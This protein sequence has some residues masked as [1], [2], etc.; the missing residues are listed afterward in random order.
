MRSYNTLWEEEIPLLEKPKKKKEEKIKIY[1]GD[2]PLYKITLW[3]DRSQGHHFHLSIDLLHRMWIIAEN[4]VPVVGKVSL[5]ALVTYR[6]LYALVT[7]R[8]LYALV[9]YRSL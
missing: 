5:Y 1:K 2:I 7:Y 3:K 4:N 6:S 8:S 9:T